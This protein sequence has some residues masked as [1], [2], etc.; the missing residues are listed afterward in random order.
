LELLDEN[1]AEGYDDEDDAVASRTLTLKHKFV[2][3]R[4]TEE[5]LD[6][7]AVHSCMHL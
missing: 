6:I 7:T 1:P 4:R 3:S 5:G 2:A